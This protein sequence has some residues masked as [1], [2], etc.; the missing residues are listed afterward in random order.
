[1]YGIC[2]RSL[3]RGKNERYDVGRRLKHCLCIITRLPYF[4]YFRVILMQVHALSLLND[5]PDWSRFY[6]DQI[7]KQYAAM[8]KPHS[9]ILIRIEKGM[10]P[11]LMYPLI[12]P[13]P[14]YRGLRINRREVS[15]I[16]LLEVLGAEKFLRLLS[17]ILCEQRILFV[18]DSIGR[19]TSSVLAAASMIAPFSWQ[20]IFIPLLPPELLDY[21]GA[22][23]PFLIGV[24]RQLLPLLED[25]YDTLGNL[26]IV[27]AD[28]GYIKTI[29]NVTTVDFIGESGSAFKQASES[30]NIVKAKASN[31][32]NILFGKSSLLDDDESNEKAA[33]SGSKD[34]VANILADLKSL[35]NSKPGGNS[36]QAV[37]SGLLRGGLL[38]GAGKNTEEARIDWI[39]EG[40]KVVR[41][42]LTSLFVYLFATLDDEVNV[43]ATK[44]SPS[45]QID[46]RVFFD[47]KSF[48]I[49]RQQLGDS[50]EIIRFLDEF[51]QSQMFERFC[52]ER[53]GHLSATKSNG[54]GS[55]LDSNSSAMQDEDEDVYNAIVSEMRNNRIPFTVASIKQIVPAKTSTN[56][57]NNDKGT[58]LGRDY[59]LLTIK[60]TSADSNITIDRTDRIII[61]SYDSNHF[62]KI[63]KTIAMRLHTAVASGCRGSSGMSGYRSLILLRDLLIQGN[64]HSRLL[65][66]MI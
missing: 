22:P 11:D 45:G 59:H 60:Q 24:H 58:K 33:Y 9:S 43:N 40:E 44:R 4:S 3:F 20:R 1:M 34:I 39:I 52:Y 32:A 42:C 56:E 16:Q 53:F 23:M 25:R 55:S 26:V 64:Y 50:K 19:L 29:G 61:D 17:M 30:F 41:D 10:V 31:M 8:N 21:V 6:L 13:T 66:S 49:K 57:N 37:T 7:Y 48:A 51:I 62:L 28:S 18:A 46:Y 2:F 27:D 12:H 14:R 36:I 5:K 38:T 15:V 63:M 54:F 65:I 47:L 35:L